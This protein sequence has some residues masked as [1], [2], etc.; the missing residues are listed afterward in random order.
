MYL[1]MAELR[2]DRHNVDAWACV[3]WVQDKKTGRG[4]FTE[5]SGNSEAYVRREASQTLEALMSQRSA[6][7]EFEWGEIQ[8]KTVGRTCTDKPVCALV[9]A[10]FQVTNWD[11]RVQKVGSEEKK[12]FWE[13]KA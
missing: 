11:N 5:H 3:A 4:L 8:M 12:R 6:Q 9:A 13:R 1:V 7:E 10:V 2:V